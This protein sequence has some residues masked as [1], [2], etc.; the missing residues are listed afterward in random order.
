MIW[1]WINNQ[2]NKRQIT[3]SRKAKDKKFHRDEPAPRSLNQSRGKGVRGVAGLRV[4][5]RLGKEGRGRR[6]AGPFVYTVAFSCTFVFE[7]RCQ[8]RQD[9]DRNRTRTEARQTQDK[10]IRTAK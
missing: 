3:T 8:T 4:R 1:Y 7:D 5:I 6:R 9:E 2:K 10:D